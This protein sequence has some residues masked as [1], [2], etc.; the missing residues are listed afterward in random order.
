[1]SELLQEDDPATNENGPLVEVNGLKTYYDTGGLFGSNPVKAVD[2]V[3]FAIDRGETLGLVGESGSGKTTLGRTLVQLESATEGE[4]LFDGTDVTTL[5]GSDL[6]NWRR[7]AQIV[8]QDPESSLNHRMTIGEIIREPLDVHDWPNFSVA[9]DDPE[10]RSVSVSGDGIRADPNESADITV[11]LA[12]AGPSI[13][14]RDALAMN[15]DSVDVSVS[16]QSSSVSVSVSVAVSKAQLRRAHVR[17]LLETVGLREEHYYRYPH[18]FSGGQR[19]RVGIARSLALEPEFVVLDEP[20]SALDVSVQAKILNLLEDLQSEFGLTYLFIA[21]DLSVVRHICDRVAVM[22]LGH[23]MEIGETEELFQNPENPYTYSLLS[24]IPEPDP[25]ADRERV[26][27]RGTPPSPRDPPSGCPFSTRCPVKIRPEAFRDVDEHTWESVET[28]RE[29]LRERENREM[30]VRDHAKALL[31]LETG[32]E[33]FVDV[34]EE[35]FTRN[36]SLE[37]EGVATEGL[38][39]SARIERALDDIDPVAREPL[40]ETIELVLAD[41]ESRAHELLVETFE[42][43]CGEQSPEHHSVSDSGRTSYCHRH[44]SEF[45]D[46]AVAFDDLLSSAE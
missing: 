1:M 7:E 6:K 19:Q 4:V 18:Q 20:V 14:V 9:V 39:D 36:G 10:D 26:T 46:T 3:D 31:G 23:I 28:L 12:G 38:D 44:R 21:H 5:S 15:A 17:D 32:F 41:K 33:D 24:A 13:A 35:V 16:E 34:A 43:D 42:S 45:D 30:G 22:Y 37:A 27:L 40:K 2:G 25:T 11:E 29:I 8:F